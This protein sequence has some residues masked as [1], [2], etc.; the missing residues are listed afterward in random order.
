MTEPTPLAKAEAAVS[1]AATN[2]D[3]VQLA[4][5]AV[6]LAKQAQQ[7]AAQQPACGHQHRTGR[8][9]SEWMAIGCAVCIGSIGLAFASIAIAIGAI[10]TAIL[11]L[12]LR[13]IWR[14]ITRGR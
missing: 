14:D 2:T 5:A 11:A 3:V 8:S 1:E 13:T 10:S 9:T 7:P 4:L 6:E 12:V